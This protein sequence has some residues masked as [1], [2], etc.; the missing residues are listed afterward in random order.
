MAVFDCDGTLVD[1]Q[2]SIVSAM[3]AACEHHGFARPEADAVRRMVGLPLDVAIQRLLP[4]IDVGFSQTM[5]ETYKSAFLDLRQAGLVEEPL[6]PGVL[7]VMDRLDAAGW[8]MGVATGKAMRGLERT[9]SHHELMGRF[10]T[11]QT[12]DRARGKPHPEMMLNAMSETGVEAEHTVMIGDTTYDVEMAANA[13]VKSIG[14]AWGYHETGELMDAGAM[15]VVHTADE[16][17]QALFAGPEG[18]E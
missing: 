15:V 5:S 8:L 9:L 6:F 13:G 1:S 17:M 2:S 11:H 4:Q 18:V 10:V 7:Q 16:L 14:V 12:A 3:F